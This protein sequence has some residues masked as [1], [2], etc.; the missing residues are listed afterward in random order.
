MAAG[1]VTA[2]INTISARK[3]AL[4]DGTDDMVEIVG[5]EIDYEV[6]RFTILAWVKT[7]TDDYLVVA[8]NSPFNNTPTSSGYG[9]RTNQSV[10][11]LALR[12]GDADGTE[13][14]VVGATSI[15][16]NIWHHVAANYDGSNIRVYLDGVED[17]IT[18]F[19]GTILFVT[20]TIKIGRSGNIANYWKGHIS[21]VKIYNR[22][23]TAAEILAASKGERIAEGLISEWLLKDD[24]TDSVGGNDGTNSGSRLG[25][26]EATTE[27]AIRAARSAA[28]SASATYLLADI[29]NGRQVVSTVIDEA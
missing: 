22:G 29:G 23:L 19:T 1:D 11:K 20:R 3:G 6:Q 8:G 9:L 15:N 7:A 28:G 25:N 16:D 2:D 4:F 21:D 10:A 13:I 5:A 26:Y 14:N 17:G 18:A 12:L 27:E 24:Y